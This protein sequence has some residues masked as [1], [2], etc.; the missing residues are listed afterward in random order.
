MKRIYM[1]MDE[2]LIRRFDKACEKAG[3]NRSQYLSCLL[4]GRLDLRPPVLQYKE[5]IRQLSDIE[6]DLKVIALK[7]GLSDDEKIRIFAGLSD[8]KDILRGRFEKE[9]DGNGTKG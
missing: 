4:A 1:T 3:L 8:V 6:R 2:D 7:D 5:M 9:E